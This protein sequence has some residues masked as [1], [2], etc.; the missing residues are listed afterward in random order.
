[1]VALVLLGASAR[2]IKNKWDIAEGITG[3]A[4]IKGKAEGHERTI[5]DAYTGLAPK[6]KLAITD[7][8]VKNRPF[9]ESAHTPRPMIMGVQFPDMPIT[10]KSVPALGDDLTSPTHANVATFTTLFLAGGQGNRQSMISQTHFGC[11]QYWHAMA[12]EPFVNGK[13]RVWSNKDLSTLIKAGAKRIWNVAKGYAKSNKPMGEFHL[14]RVLHTIGDSFATGHT[15]R[16]PGC[17]KIQVFQE[18]NAQAGNHAHDDGDK[19]DKNT[20]LFACA[21][22]RVRQVMT[23]WAACT[24]GENDCSYPASIIDPTYEVEPDVANQDAGGSIAKFAGK[25][26]TVKKTFKVNGQ[27]LDVFFPVQK[28]VREAGTTDPAQVCAHF[29]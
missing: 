23:Y 27:N 8:V 17:G 29:K 20:A 9:L 16:S 24:R 14:G 5:R 6:D 18:Y 10:G 28:G 7:P 22:N 15:V 26:A 2:I 3:A 4:S 21:V 19:P 12:P 1:L 13:F 11:L 25:S